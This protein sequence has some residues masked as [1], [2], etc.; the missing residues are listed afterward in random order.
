MKLGRGCARRLDASVERPELTV[1]CH[2]PPHVCNTTGQYPAISETRRL[3]HWNGSSTL[4]RSGGL[5]KR[6]NCTSVQKMCPRRDAICPSEYVRGPQML[7]CEEHV[8]DL[9]GRRGEVDGVRKVQLTDARLPPQLAM[10]K[11]K[12][13][14]RLAVTLN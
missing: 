9:S 12:W 5:T 13:H 14:R 1:P 2:T 6:W 8:V 4:I 3:D 11:E 7:L 10:T